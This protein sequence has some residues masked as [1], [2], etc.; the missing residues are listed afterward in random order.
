MAQIIVFGDIDITPLYISI[1]GTKELVVSGKWPRRIPV[2]T[3]PCHIAATTIT[4][5]QR[6]LRGPSDDFL[7]WAANAMTDGTNTSL[8]GT[9]DLDSND[10]WLF[11]V[12]QTLSK[13]KV[14]NQVV[15]ASK[16]DQYVNMD[17]VLDYGERAPGEKNKWVVFLLCLLLG[18]FGIHRFYEKKFVT[19]ILYLLTMGLFGFGVLYDL[20]KIWQ[21]A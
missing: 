14:Y 6:A 8:A 11:Q 16:V 10:V 5:T 1:N 19:G 18:V 15:D 12:K 9:V 4:K 20:V 17:T 2:K 7:G 3:G 13:S 21:R